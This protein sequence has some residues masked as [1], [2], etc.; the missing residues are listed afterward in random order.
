M[1]EPEIRLGTGVWVRK[2]DLLLIGL[3]NTE[4]G[5][6]TWCPPGGHVDPGEDH[7]TCA[8]REIVEEAAIEIDNLRDLGIVMPDLRADLNVLYKTTFYSADW[9]A[10]EPIPLPTEYDEWRW[11][12]WEDMPQPLFRPAALF[13]EKYGN[14][15][16]I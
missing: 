4:S 9:K 12:R 5:K 15:L 13:V 14:P 1:S 11:V 8:R 10:G 16:E 7:E 3:R 2:G 6:G